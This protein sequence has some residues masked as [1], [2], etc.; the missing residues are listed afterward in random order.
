MFVACIRRLRSYSHTLQGD[1]DSGG[2]LRDSGGYLRDSGFN[3]HLY[4]STTS[5]SWDDTDFITIV[6][7]CLCPLQKPDVFA[8]DI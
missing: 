4:I 6:E 8:V 3:S 5:D 2:Y 7:G 1:G